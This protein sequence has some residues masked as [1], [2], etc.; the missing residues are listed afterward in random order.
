MKLSQLLLSFLLMFIITTITACGYKPSSY[1]A[2]QQIKG[3]VFV[4][5][6]IDLKDPRNAVLIKDAMN[7]ILVHRLDSKIV[8]DKTLADTIMDVKLN[9][10]SMTVLQDDADGN[11]ILY[12]A[13][14][15]VYVKY[16]NEFGTKTFNVTGDYDFSIDDD[17]TISD[18]KRF[19]AIKSA[20]SEALEEVISK[21]AIQSLKK[22]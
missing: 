13:T 7:E 3:K 17:T 21:I 8:Y 4:N 22:D 14:V 6:I 11:D 19:E 12:K 16:S 20:A 2:K 15:G 9:S 10:V 5:L 18:T 1:Y